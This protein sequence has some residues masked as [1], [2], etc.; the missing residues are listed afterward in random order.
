MNYE[1][2]NNFLAILTSVAGNPSMMES[3]SIPYFEKK[4]G[5]PD[6]EGV[7]FIGR[8]SAGH[9]HWKK[10]GIASDSYKMRWQVSGSNG[11]CQTFSI[12]GYLGK[13]D[14][15]VPGDY[16]KNNLEAL[17]F[18][19][20]NYKLIW[21]YWEDVSK[22]LEKH[23]YFPDHRITQKKLRDS[24]QALIDL[25]ELTLQKIITEEIVYDES[26]FQKELVFVCSECGKEY[27]RETSALNHIKT[28]HKEG[29]IL[30]K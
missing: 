22:Q 2:L 9:F 15:L 25:P 23:I 26:A 14:G 17:K 8:D 30:E 29:T 5:K 7:T 18:L 13:T 4:R 20:R 6:N 21:S 19:L 1:Y 10:D 11:F 3:L 16:Y 12:M 24:I 27:K 28:K